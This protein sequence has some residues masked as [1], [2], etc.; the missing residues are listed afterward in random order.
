MTCLVAFMLSSY[1]FHQVCG[2]TQLLTIVEDF[3]S[4]DSAS[5]KWTNNAS[6]TS[7]PMSY[8]A[9]SWNARSQAVNSH[10]GPSPYPRKSSWQKK[11]PDSHGVDV[12]PFSDNDLNLE[13][14]FA[15][16]TSKFSLQEIGHEMVVEVT[17]WM[18]RPPYYR[19][20]ADIPTGLSLN[21]YRYN[22]NTNEDEYREV[23][24]FNKYGEDWTTVAVHLQVPDP[25]NTRVIPIHINL[26][27][28]KM[29]ISSSLAFLSGEEFGL[30]EQS[31][32]F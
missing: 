3:K 22:E 10:F 16:L 28:C 19:A 1:V 8:W 18:S 12:F 24:W 11:G 30:D 27:V 20:L 15:L 13:N 31:G 17:Y 25:S 29:Y 2:S 4:P 21:T 14:T 23:F 6:Y 26:N 7:N 9:R 5:Y 32:H